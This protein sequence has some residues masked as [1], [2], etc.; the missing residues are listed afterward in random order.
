MWKR[1]NTGRN[2]PGA[3]IVADCGYACGE[4]AV[5][6]WRSRWSYREPWNPHPARH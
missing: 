3:V 2:T 5:R 1:C 6:G 4:V